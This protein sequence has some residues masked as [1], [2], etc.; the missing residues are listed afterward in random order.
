MAHKY[1][2][3]DSLLIKGWRI[4]LSPSATR[5]ERSLASRLVSMLLGFSDDWLAQNKEEKEEKATDVARAWL[6]KNH[7]GVKHM[8]ATHS[9]YVRR[10]S[11]D[12]PS[13]TRLNA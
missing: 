11:A 13:Y 8:R 2:L 5:L 4:V 3:Q 1:A 10:I 9:E 6:H 7:T 12:E